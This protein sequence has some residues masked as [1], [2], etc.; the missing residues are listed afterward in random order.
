MVGRRIL[1]ASTLA[2]SSLLV[3]TS[4]ASAA[5]TAT[6]G[7]N[8]NITKTAG[9]Q[10]EG[11]IAINPS[12]SS[13][14]FFASNPGAFSR[15][16][17]DGGATWGA[18]GAG[19]GASCCDNVAA[20]DAFGN[21]FVVNIS[22]PLGTINLFLSTD[23]GANFTLLQAIDTGSVDQPSVKAAA[24]SVWVT[25]N[26]GTIKARGAAVTGLGAIGAFTAE[27]A[28]GAGQF[29]DIE[30]GPTGQVVVTYQ[31]SNSPCPCTIF[32]ATDANGIAAGGFSPRVTVSSTNVNTFDFIP[33]QSGRS[34]DAEANLAWDRSGGAFNGR[35]YIAYTDEAPDESNDTNNFV[36]FSTDN[37]ATWSAAV[38]VNDDATTRSQFLPNVSIDQTTGNLAVTWHDA[39][40]DAANGSAQFWGA[41]S[42]TGG[43]SFGANFQISAGT[44]NDNAAGSGV[45]YG[46]YTTSTFNAGLLYPVWSDNSNSTGD[47]PNGANS[48]LDMYTAKITVATVVVNS[49]PVLTVPGAQT[50]DFNDPLTFGVSATDANAGD[51]LAFSASGLPAGL[52]L[53]DNLNRTAT[54]TGTVSATPAVYTATISVNDGNNPAVTA[55]VQITVTKEQTAIAQSGAFTQ[56]Y[57]DPYTASATL[58]DPDGGA[59]IAAKSITF[60]LG[61]GDT[62]TATT[63]VAGVASCSITPT[64]AAGTLALVA[65]FTGDANY[66]S[67][68][69][70][71]SFVITKEETTAQYTGPLVIANGLPVIL[72]GKL[73][74]DGVTA[75]LGRTLTLSVGSQTCTGTTNGTGDASCSIPT[76]SVPFGPVTVKADFA[77][78][79]FYLPSS[80]SKT[81][82]VFAFPERGDFV[83]GDATAAAAGPTTT[84]TFW[85]AQWASLN[86]LSVGVVEPS[87]KGFAATPSSTPPACG[88]TWL[89][90]PGNSSMPTATVPSYMGVAVAAEVTKSGSTISG[91]IVHIV[92]VKT[93]PGYAPDPG[94][95]GTGTIVAT[96][97]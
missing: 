47:N 89:T 74:E 41:V 90:R 27:Q 77:G 4:V 78:D 19:I 40:N 26:D 6:V 30:I 67:S 8:V 52:T 15:R 82:I 96:Y 88:G 85:G 49:P 53:T 65:A 23:G 22:S 17:T 66:L 45:D 58:T 33:A 10:A 62:C 43:S 83:L 36:R 61:V 44:S 69:N 46:D 57:N 28:A 70:S 63:S 72:K 35:L 68:S 54:V 59:P 51:T 76:V 79:G 48:A 37:G 80:E 32:A 39:R 81:A 14:L 25:W 5:L 21:L 50:V 87:F 42:D 31:S 91:N 2:V 95:P 92:V 73:L 55:T 56:D 9:N 11:T 16:S 12:N 93:N 71:R 75:I 13:Q 84:V 97:C 24:G 29:G 86:T 94:N 64:Q 38:R 20:W 7:T 3:R 1:I 18:A 60:T 34:I